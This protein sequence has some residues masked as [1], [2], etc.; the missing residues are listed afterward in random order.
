MHRNTVRLAL[1][2]VAMFYAV[3]GGLWAIDYFPMANFYRQS[4]ITK[5][6]MSKSHDYEFLKSEEFQRAS[7]SEEAYIQAHPDLTATRHRIELYQSILLWGTVALGVGGG[8]LF[9]TRGKRAG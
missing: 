6:I 3:F 5:G 2:G 4:E 9:L 1:A 7:R 8:V